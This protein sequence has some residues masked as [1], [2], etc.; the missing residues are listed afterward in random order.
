VPVPDW[1]DG[2]LS[3]WIEAAE[4]KTGSCSVAS[5]VRAGLGERGSPRNCILRSEAQGRN[6]VNLAAMEVFMKRPWGTNIEMT[7][8]LGDIK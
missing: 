3:T 7:E 6:R 2:E 4:I 1:V 5:V 8:G